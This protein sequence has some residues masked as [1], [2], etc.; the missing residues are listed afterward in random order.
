MSRII[1]IATL[2]YAIAFAQAELEW[3]LAWGQSLML[4][5]ERIAEHVQK[6]KPPAPRASA[7]S[8]A[9]RP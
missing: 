4:I 5:Q 7:A 8:T 9:P 6:A 1:K 2:G 3:A